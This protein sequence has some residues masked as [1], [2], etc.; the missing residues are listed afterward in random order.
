MEESFSP[1]CRLAQCLGRHGITQNADKFVFCKADVEFAGF[2][3]TVD[4]VW[5]GGKYLQASDDF[6]TSRNI[7]D[8][9]SW[10]GLVNQVSYAFSMA[11]QMQ[12]FRQLLKPCTPF[13]WNDHLNRLFK[14]S[15][16]VIIREIE[17]GVKIFDK[18][19]PTCLATDWS[20]DGIGFWLCQKH[21]TCPNNV[22]VCCPDG[23]KITLVE[24][25]F[26]HPA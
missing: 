10:F 7:T 4:S 18:G 25:R 15:K 2:T 14:E 13:T 19:K 9:R 16:P 20:K 24:S 1:G 12:P 5:P 21:C 11:N 17:K 8:I 22:P 23:W 26:T 6:P 3:I